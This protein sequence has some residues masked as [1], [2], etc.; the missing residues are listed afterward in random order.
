MSETG[1]LL[2]PENGQGATQGTDEKGGQSR[3]CWGARDSLM[4]NCLSKQGAKPGAG[5]LL[6]RLYPQH[7]QQFP[8]P[9][10]R[11]SLN[12]RQEN[13]REELAMMNTKVQRWGKE[14]IKKESGG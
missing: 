10:N 4:L 6:P 3:R 13:A 11:G 2:Q 7:P 9:Q 12:M 14:M 5:S 1:F 8:L